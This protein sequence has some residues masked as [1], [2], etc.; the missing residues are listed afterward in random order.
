VNHTQAISTLRDKLRDRSSDVASRQWSDSVLAS[1]ID[2]QQKSIF[3]DLAKAAEGYY[4]ER[5]KLFGS[6]ACQVHTGVWEYE[7]PVW[8][9]NIIEQGVRISADIDAAEGTRV[10]PS[11]DVQFPSGVSWRYDGTHTLRLWHASA[12]DLT[13]QV[14][15]I[16]G[17]PLQG[18][19][20]NATDHGPDVMQ[21]E[22]DASAAFPHDLVPDTYVGS[23][24]EITAC[25]NSENVG[26]QRRVV[27]SGVEELTTGVRRL[28]LRFA[29]PFPRGIPTGTG[30][31]SL[32][33]TGSMA[34]QEY[35][36]LM[37]KVTA[38][39]DNDSPVPESLQAALRVETARF[40]DT[41]KRRENV[42]ARE[43]GV[44]QEYFRSDQPDRDPATY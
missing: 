44:E 20:D 12:Q 17:P 18:T 23:I 11:P 14:A 3:R 31:V 10:R 13:V 43:H 40:L 37:T 36:L 32:I 38:L 1:Y 16:P 33:D 25:T 34:H 29:K 21:C 30:Y 27:S 26:L 7:L 4:N 41:L 19:T 6:E 2:G 9:F 22:A 5:V 15:K 24:I 35:L 8:V 28:T 42:G 39:S